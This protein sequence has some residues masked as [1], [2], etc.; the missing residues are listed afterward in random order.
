[1]RRIAWV[2]VMLAVLIAAYGCANYGAIKP[3]YNEM[4]IEMLLNNWKDYDVSWTGLSVGEPTALMFDP[5][6]DG[7]KLV[8]DI[9]HPVE[10]KEALV[11][12]VSWLKANQVYYPF[13]WR[14]LGPDGQFYGYL[15]SGCKYAVVKPMNETTVWV[16]GIPATLRGED[17]NFNFKD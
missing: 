5:K 12:F 16:Y 15:Y 9:W 8:G 10:S 6:D 7:K 2:T 1:M 3:A 4:T 11:G 13:V 17:R 14:I